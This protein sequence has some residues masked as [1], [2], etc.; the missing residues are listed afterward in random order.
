M[1][2]ILQLHFST[3]I[4]GIIERSTTPPA[5]SRCLISAII[6]MQKILSSAQKGCLLHL[7]Y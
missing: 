5:E 3:S 4:P 2:Y 7:K 1:M 6:E